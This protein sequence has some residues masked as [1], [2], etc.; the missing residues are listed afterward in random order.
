VRAVYPIAKHD[1]LAGAINMLTDTVKCAL[2]AD[3]YNPADLSI[4][5]VTVVATTNVSVTDITDDGQVL[6]NDITF[7]SVSGSPVTG[8]VTYIDGG[9]LVGYTNQ[10]ADTVPIDITPNGGDITLSFP[11]LVKL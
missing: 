7:A 1:L 6:C 9:P 4:A 3:D 8:V 5:D 11:Y 10:R 2:V